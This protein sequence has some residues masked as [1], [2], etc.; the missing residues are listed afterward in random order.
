MA[1]NVSDEM[2]RMWQE[3]AAKRR[4]NGIRLGRWAIMVNR[5]QLISIDEFYQSWVKVLGKE[6]AADYLIVVMRY[7]HEKLRIALENRQKE[8][9]RGKT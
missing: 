6:K 7:G 2:K 1:S 4:A 9:K 5:D 3:A 8:K